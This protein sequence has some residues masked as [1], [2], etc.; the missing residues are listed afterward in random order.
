MRRT[1]AAFHRKELPVTEIDIELLSNEDKLHCGEKELILAGG[2]RLRILTDLYPLKEGRVFPRQ[3]ISISEKDVMEIFHTPGHSADSICFMIGD[4]LFL[5]DLTFA[6]N[7]GIA[8]LSGWNQKD[9]VN[10]LEGLID[11]INERRIGLICPGHG[12]LIPGDKA[13]AILQKQ[14]RIAGNLTNIREWDL[15]AFRE[16]SQYA[17]EMLA[18]VND[19][20]AI[21][22]G[23]LYY[24]AYYLEELGEPAEAQK[25]REFISLEAI[26]E[27]LDEYDNCASALQRG[28]IY[29][30]IMVLR[31]TRLLEKIQALLNEGKLE[32]IMDKY[33]MRRANRLF[34][35]FFIV[36]SGRPLDITLTN[37]NINELLG[38]LLAEVK[39]KQY[40]E[41]YILEVLDDDE[42]Y[43]EA[44]ATRIAFQPVL[45]E[46]KWSF[47]PGDVVPVR[48]NPERFAEA[49]TGLLED[50]ATLD[51]P[52]LRIATALQ[53]QGVVVRTDSINGIPAGV[54]N[55]KRFNAHRRRIELAG[56]QLQ[57]V[58]GGGKVR[59]EITFSAAAR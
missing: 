47:S 12:W 21:I 3:K 42:L 16:V 41:D 31:T 50:I 25:Y 11:L 26:E 49:Y 19:M 46:V 53:E 2:N 35:D 4:V 34:S 9:L 45:Q 10:T 55:E 13:V 29:D 28:E 32:L 7:S 22:A 5:G 54:F 18:D 23:R 1:T 48:L 20:V 58:T 52:D 27:L 15:A 44:L 43:L 37:G 33:F 51:V 57:K 14:L 24:L 30:N 40:N 39:R 8:G 6:G 17:L 56:G 38:D 59:F 36:S